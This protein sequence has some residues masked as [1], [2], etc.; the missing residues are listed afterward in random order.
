MIN[1][2][3]YSGGAVRWMDIIRGKTIEHL[4]TF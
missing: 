3:E 4:K 1:I 2:W